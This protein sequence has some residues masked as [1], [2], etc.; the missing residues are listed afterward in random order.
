MPPEVPGQT[1]EV[2]ARVP[3]G[4]CEAYFDPADEQLHV[5]CRPEVVAKLFGVS[6]GEALAMIGGRVP[7][8]PELPRAALSPE[9][10]VLFSLLPVPGPSPLPP[11]PAQGETVGG[12]E[13]EMSGAR[14][15]ASPGGRRSAHIPM[16]LP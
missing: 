9:A 15:E 5:V 3:L 2:A 6:E 11:V 10:G 12:M 8:A 14:V 7:V 16:T 13:A 4:P 1:P